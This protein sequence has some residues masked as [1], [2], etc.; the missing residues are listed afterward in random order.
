MTTKTTVH[1]VAYDLLRELGL[2]TIFGNPGSTEETFLSDFPDDFTYVLAL[3]EASA[4]A[5]ADGFAQATRRPTLVNLHSHAGLGNG[6][7]N[8]VN[9]SQ[10]HTPLIVMV[11][12][13]HREMMIGD[14]YLSNPDAP[15]TPRPWVKWAYEPYRAEDVP[16]ALMRAFVTASQPPAGP[17]FLSVPLDDWNRPLEGPAVRRQSS[18][19]FAPETER[20]RHFAD[21]IADSDNPALVFGPDVDRAEGWDA[22]VAL[23]EKTN[24]GVYGTPLPDRVS[25]PEDHPLYQ[26]PIGESLKSISTTLAG[27]DLVVV[28]G[29][30]VFRYYAF[31]EGD[32]LEPGTDLLHI[33]HDPHVAAAARVGDSILGELRQST[34]LLTEMISAN[35]RKAPAPMDRTHTKVPKAESGPLTPDQVYAALADVRPEHAVLVNESTST[36]PQHQEWLPTVE[37]DSNYATPAG[38][39]GW[40]LPASVGI[41]LGN[42]DRGDTRPVIGLIGDGSFQYS[43]QSLWSAAQHKLPNVYVAMRNG[44]YAV[45]KEFG[46]IEHTPG[47]PGLELPGL[48]IAS[49]ARGFGCAAVDVSTTEELKREFTAALDKTSGGPTVIVVTT[50]PDYGNHAAG[51]G[52]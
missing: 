18:T 4:V 17:V 6:M 51:P 11:G 5:M 27:H 21:R 20:L 10:A 33:T 24:A 2:T 12:N 39:I 16:A 37:P 3:Q 34:E 28:I 26:G 31:E 7:G 38:G 36:M 29:A 46:Q 15:V 8:I 19:S 1:N 41:A 50:R 32:V 9:A 13:Q 22:A 25:F 30:Q 14:P 52:G 35:G 49:I 45:L 47:V 43:I 48:D 23:A 44:E 40:A 42:R